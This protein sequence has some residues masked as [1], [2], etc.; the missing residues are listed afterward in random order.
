MMKILPITK[1]REDLP[2]IVDRANRLLSKYTITVNGEPKAVVMSYDEYE[3]LQE[4]LDI[5]SDPNALKD[6]KKAEEEYD[7][8]NY[9]TWDELKKELKW[10]V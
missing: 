7:K 4:T 6:I 3:S 8:G 10:D 9:I 5:L 1:I 2:N